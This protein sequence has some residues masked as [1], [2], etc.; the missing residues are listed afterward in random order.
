ME[1][2]QLFEIFISKLYNFPGVDTTT[3]QD[4][5]EYN[6]EPVS[7]SSVKRGN[8]VYVEVK[9]VYFLWFVISLNLI[10]TVKLSRQQVRNVIDLY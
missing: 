2:E 3:E 7:N 9:K 5:T 1:K 4:E 8:I 6:F 10:L